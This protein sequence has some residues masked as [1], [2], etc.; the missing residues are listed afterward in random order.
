[1]HYYKLILQVVLLKVQLPCHLFSNWRHLL[2]K[3]LVLI[4]STIRCE[5]SRNHIHWSLGKYDF[6]YARTW[7]GIDFAK[8]FT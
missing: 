8:F 4:I 1:M 3:G 6:M 5:S 7:L 2:Q